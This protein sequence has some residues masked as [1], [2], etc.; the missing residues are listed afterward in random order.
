MKLLI[1]DKFNDCLRKYILHCEN[2]DWVEGELYKF[3]FAN[4]LNRKV[5]LRIQSEQKIYELCMQSMKEP[6]YKNE[7]GIQFIIRGARYKVSQPISLPDA[8]LFKILSKKD[9]LTLIG[10][11]ERGMSFPV[12]S[13]WLGT[14]L[15]KKFVSVSTTD[16]IPVI[17]LLFGTTIASNGIE[18]F[19]QSQE[20]FQVIKQELKALSIKPY[21]L[22]EINKYVK[23]LYPHIPEKKLYDECDWNW[24]TEDFALYIFRVYLDLYVPKIKKPIDPIKKKR[25]RI[26][27]SG[28]VNEPDQDLTPEITEILEEPEPIIPEV[29]LEM[30][31]SEYVDSL[32]DLISLDKKYRNATPEVKETISKR[33]ERGS[34]SNRFK[35]I[36]GYK[37]MI[38]ERMGH[39]PYSFS[40]PNGDYYIET[41]H[42]IPVSD[43]VEGSLSSANLITVCANHHRQL[44]FGKCYV[45]EI[46]DRKFVFQID[47]KLW[48][49]KKLSALIL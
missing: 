1:R 42:V 35:Q 27:V 4:W 23:E 16:F 47:N 38:C 15:P 19:N 17:D 32:V 40:K 2:S 49:I 33:I 36:A 31:N 3:R 37:C 21:F 29:T 5:N 10:T 48:D 45:Q 8:E 13:A 34:F 25:A 18:F 44:H 43:L 46:T 41:H 39:N 28:I 30:A 12:L 20:Y 14:L 26:I 11:Y 22:P 24:V 9:D 6:F 7:K